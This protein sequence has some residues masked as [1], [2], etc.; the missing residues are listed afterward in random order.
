MPPK[1]IT[2]RVFA[3]KFWGVGKIAV[4]YALNFE[5]LTK[6]NANNGA[7]FRNKSIILV[8][9]SIVLR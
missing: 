2:M 5:M 3:L 6:E 9:I 8:L 4:K 1:S 7:Q